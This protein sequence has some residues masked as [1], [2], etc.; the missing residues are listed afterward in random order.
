MKPVRCRRIIY[1]TMISVS[2]SNHL[3]LIAGLWLANRLLACSV[4]LTDSEESED[5]REREGKKTIMHY[6]GFVCSAKTNFKF[7]GTPI[8]FYS[9]LSPLSRLRVQEPP[10]K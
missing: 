4:S 1:A 5:L 8:V 3:F 6:L 10:E 9:P 7:S 2:F